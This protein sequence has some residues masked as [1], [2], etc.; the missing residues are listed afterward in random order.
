[1]P[2]PIKDAVCGPQ[3][4]GTMK[5]S[6]GTDLSSLNSCPL[7]VCSDVWGY[8]GTTAEFLTKTPAN[9]GNPETTI[10]DTSSC[11]FNCGMNTVNNGKPPS[12]FAKFGHFEGFSIQ[13]SC[14][15]MDASQIN[16]SA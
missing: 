11:I 8:C 1:M 2:T 16:V 9:N 10:P 12:N 15:R 3:V 14:L 6:K 5:P 13:R 7:K 4:P